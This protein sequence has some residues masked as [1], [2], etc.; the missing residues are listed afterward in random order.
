MKLAFIVFVVVF[1]SSVFA[2]EIGKIDIVES[3]QILELVNRK[4]QEN[5]LSKT[6]NGYRVQLHFG[7]DREKAREVKSKFLQSFPYIEAYDSYQQPNFRIRV[8]DFRTRL[9]AIKFLKEIQSLFPSA[10]I[11]NDYISLPKL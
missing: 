6:I 9:Q 3:K 4:L 10:F 1:N 2:Q 11:V 5:Q 8:G 7:N